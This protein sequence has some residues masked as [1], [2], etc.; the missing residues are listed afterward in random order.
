LLL[1]DDS[2]PARH[3]VSEIP[4]AKAEVTEYRRHKL[5]CLSC[6]AVTEADWPAEMPGGSFGPR[7]QVTIGYLTGRLGMSHRDVVEA[8]E[9]LHG[10]KIGLNRGNQDWY[11][12]F[13][14]QK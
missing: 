14:T 2:H 8:L 11:T 10:L 13:A 6:G 4:M 5:A 12:R 1:G 9:T 3:Q 7:A